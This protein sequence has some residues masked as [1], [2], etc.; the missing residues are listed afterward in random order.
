[1]RRRSE[2]PQSGNTKKERGIDLKEHAG[3]KEED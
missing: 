1:M 2:E 3:V